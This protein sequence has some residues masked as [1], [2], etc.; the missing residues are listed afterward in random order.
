MSEAGEATM[1]LR[2]LSAGEPAAA[3]DLAPIIYAEL[4]EAAQAYMRRESPGPLLQTTALAHD[5]YLKLVDQT[6]VEWRD[7][8][9][10]LAVAST[11]MRRILIDHARTEKRLKRGGDQKPLTLS[12][13]NIAVDSITNVDLLA[14]GEALDKLE[15]I[16]PIRMNIVQMRFFGGMTMEEI[17]R[18]LD[19]SLR[20]VEQHWR[21]ARIWLHRELADDAASKGAS[22]EP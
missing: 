19:R 5:A 16:D 6:R 2:K 3:E 20:S 13:V 22:D 9:H 15:A 8:A 11:I 10:F 21:S 12:H 1:L 18:M 4:H 17:A 14:L 7:R